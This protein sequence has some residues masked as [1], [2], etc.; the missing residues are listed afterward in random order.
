MVTQWALVYKQ[1][2]E[3]EWC[4]ICGV[5]VVVKFIAFGH[6]KPREEVKYLYARL[7]TRH[8]YLGHRAAETVWWEETV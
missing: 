3:G 7:V 5:F 6:G 4:P 2:Q 8:K 1:L